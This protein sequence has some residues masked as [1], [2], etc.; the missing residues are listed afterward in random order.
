MKTWL[1]RT[2]Y[3]VAALCAALLLFMGGGTLGYSRGHSDASRSQAIEFAEGKVSFCKLD[4]DDRFFVCP[5]S[6]RIRTAPDGGRVIVYVCDS[7][8]KHGYIEF[9]NMKDPYRAQ[10]MEKIR[11]MKQ[12][13]AKV[14]EPCETPFGEIYR[15]SPK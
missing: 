4:E 6:R 2:L 7:P 9:Y 15:V 14:A 12:H 5:V 11:R 10:A 8:G 13:G 1:K 3:M